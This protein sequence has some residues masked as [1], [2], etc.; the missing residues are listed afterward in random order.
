MLNQAW[1]NFMIAARGGEPE[2]VPV[3]L[4]VDCGFIASAFGID[5]LDFYMY[6]DRWLDAYVT[7]MARF[8]EVVFLPGFWVEFGMAAEPSAFGTPVMWRHDQAPAMRHL[9]LSQD[10]W[11]RLPQP[12]PYSDGLMALVL[13]RYWNLE[14]SGELTEPHRIH[15]VAA[16]GPFTIAAHVLGG[17][18]FLA[19][20]DDE[21]GST[22]AV[23]DVLD[24][25]TETTIRFL[26]AQLGCLREPLGVVV[27]DDI[28]GGLTANAF[29]RYAAPFLQR[30]F[31][32]FNG[33]VRVFRCDTPCRP[34][35]PQLPELGFEVFHF[36]HR[37]DMREVRTTLGSQIALMG[38]VSALE[39]MARGMPEQVESAG[40]ECIARAGKSSALILSAAGTV[41]SGT[42]TENIDALVRAAGH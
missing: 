21:P 41:L 7:L 19:A 9:N 24:I 1:E 35:L 8:P 3:A 20:L 14:H 30:I 2:S 12:D 29:G 37:M 13:R 6:P 36:S 25:F 38:N 31:K 39:I 27:L 34:V 33:L 15:F 5:A 23:L 32:T 4:N 40:R 28:V 11:A 22:S 17:S 42:P 26:R 10:D 18:Q 16:R